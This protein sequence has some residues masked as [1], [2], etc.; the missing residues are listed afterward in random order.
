MKYF[1]ILFIALLFSSCHRK[2]DQAT[3]PGSWDEVVAAGTGST[4]RMMMWQGDPFIN[5]YMQQYV[6][7]KL[8]ELYGIELEISSGQGNMIVSLLLS[9][10]EAGKKQ[11]SIDMMWINGETFYQ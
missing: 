5:T 7:P 10:L 6:K 2:G 4:V 1:S 8:K 9:E 11:S 3:V